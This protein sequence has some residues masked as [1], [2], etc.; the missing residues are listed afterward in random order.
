MK[1]RT[2]IGLAIL[3]AC[4]TVPVSAETE[5]GRTLVH[6]AFT[7]AERQV[8]AR[9]YGDTDPNVSHHET[10]SKKHKK[11]K[12]KGKNGLPP[13]LAKKHHLP[14]GLAKREI[15]P[16]GLSRQALPRDL[17]RDLPPVRDGLERV[18][19]DGSIVLIEQATGVV[20]DIFEHIVTGE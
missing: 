6:V 15:L 1:Y 17:I 20:L 10:K 12:G 19:I 9:Y 8:M 7:T 11:G 14:P 4:F 13:G 16:P 3:A 2:L 5:L 18:I